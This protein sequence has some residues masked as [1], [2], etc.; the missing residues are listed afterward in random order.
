LG[1]AASGTGNG[2][3]SLFESRR[4]IYLS[5]FQLS[6]TVSGNGSVTPLSQDVEPGD[7]AMFS[8]TPAPNWH[9]ADVSGDTC[10][11]VDDGGSSWSVASINADCAVLVTFAIDQYSLTYAAGENGTL[12][13]NS[14]QLVDHGSSGTAVQAVPDGGYQFAQ[15]S[16]GV[17][18]NPRIDSNV[19]AAVDVTAQ[20]VLG[21]PEVFAD[22]F[23]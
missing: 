5:Q 16:D 13:G 9:L 4:Q 2:A 3:G 21:V 15:W 14:A 7:P 11:P 17:L 12:S 18:A 8:V 6:V 20:F 23:E 22:G 1:R 19:T 10:D